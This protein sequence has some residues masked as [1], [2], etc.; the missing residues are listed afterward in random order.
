MF[1]ENLQAMHKK[2]LKFALVVELAQSKFT[3]IILQKKKKLGHIA[4]S[5]SRQFCPEA[6]VHVWVKDI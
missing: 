2:I 5:G 4:K 1:H 6:V 3:Y